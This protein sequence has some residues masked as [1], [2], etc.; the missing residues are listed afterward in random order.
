MRAFAAIETGVLSDSTAYFLFTK[1]SLA[2][3]FLELPQVFCYRTKESNDGIGSCRLD[4][5]K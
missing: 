4:Y 2:G 3:G 5:L 1:I